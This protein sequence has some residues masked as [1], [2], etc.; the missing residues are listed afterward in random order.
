MPEFFLGQQPVIHTFKTAVHV[1]KAYL[2]TFFS[3]KE[4][5]NLPLL[6]LAC[7]LNGLIE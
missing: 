6:K 1:A 4:G 3:I 7:F 2:V 5:Q